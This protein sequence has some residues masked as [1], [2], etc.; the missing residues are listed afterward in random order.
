MTINNE[1]IILDF[2]E[3]VKIYA[4][5]EF[6]KL[7]NNKQYASA[8]TFQLIRDNIEQNIQLLQSYINISKEGDYYGR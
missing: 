1:K 7:C 4:G 6:E 2:L 5:A 8:L 3:T